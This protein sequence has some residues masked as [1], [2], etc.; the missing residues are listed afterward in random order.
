MPLSLNDLNVGYP[1]FKIKIALLEQH[2]QEIN[3]NNIAIDIKGT[4]TQ[5]YACRR[6][7]LFCSGALYIN[8]AAMTSPAP[9]INCML[10]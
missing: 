9:M 3:P 10:L 5:R 2:S 1:N 4:K 6:G 8:V 7:L